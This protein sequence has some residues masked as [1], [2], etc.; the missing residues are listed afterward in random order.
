MGNLLSRVA[1][2]VSSTMR[3][4]LVL[5]HPVPR[6]GYQLLSTAL[7]L[8]LLALLYH[9]LKHREQWSHLQVVFQQLQA[10]ENYV[11]LLLALLLMPFNWL[12]ETGKWRQL[13]Q[14]Y[15]PMSW[16]KAQ[17]A[18]WVGL[19][20]SLFMPNRT[21][22]FAGRILF[23]RPENRRFAITANL[24]GNYAQM[25]VTGC[26]G[27][28]GLCLL[29]STLWYPDFAGPVLLVVAAAAGCGVL[30][31]LYLRLRYL[32]RYLSRTPH[33]L[34]KRF[35][36]EIL[37]F[38]ACHALEWRRLLGWAILR[39]ALF[40]SQYYF[41]L[42]FFGV[43]PGIFLAFA[44]IS[45]LFLFQTGIPLPPLAGLLARGN[46][47]VFLWGQMGAPEVCS[48]AA[49]FALWIINLILPA[50]VG[51][52]SLFFVNIVKTFTHENDQH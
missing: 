11:W 23:V 33:L 15:E 7:T 9:E 35:A 29:F 1:H 16:W 44:G 6:F 46:A 26:M 12:A 5:S 36:K 8:L 18:V 24:I 37:F 19:A 27:L 30:L 45:A 10:A 39:Y 25:T 31:F 41:L 21:G 52:F 50:L 49:T 28:W 3:L 17:Q 40:A 4:P 43:K 42:I 20:V 47:A 48:L 51:T 32:P 38:D 2:F 14:Q 22:E 34:V 13:L